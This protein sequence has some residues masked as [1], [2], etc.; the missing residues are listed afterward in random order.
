MNQ[1]EGALRL[2]LKC[3]QQQR[4]TTKSEKMKK[5]LFLLFF[6]LTNLSLW[7]QG[8][9]KITVTLPETYGTTDTLFEMAGKG[10]LVWHAAP[11]ADQHPMTVNKDFRLKNYAKRMA[12][13]TSLFFLSGVANGIHDIAST[14]AKYNLSVLPKYDG[15]FW[16]HKDQTWVNKW[17]LDK[18]GDPMVGNERFWGSSTMF[19]AGT[20]LWHASKTA[21]ITCFEIGLLTYDKP[22]KFWK[23]ALDMVILKTAFSAGWHLSNTLLM[24]GGATN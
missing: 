21:T 11:F 22:D 3:I 16:G 24:R 2:L 6:L 8:N 14:S 17:E 12:V 13:P 15:G 7:S 4:F 5:P 9:A 19:S 20:D 10:T 23:K 1:E 18:N